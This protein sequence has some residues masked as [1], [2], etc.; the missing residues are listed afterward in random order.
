MLIEV[1]ERSLTRGAGVY[2]GLP[3]GSGGRSGD[4]SGVR[5]GVLSWRPERKAPVSTISLVLFGD[6]LRVWSRVDPW[7]LLWGVSKSEDGDVKR[8]DADEEEEEVDDVLVECP[9]LASRSAR[10]RAALFHSC[11]WGLSAA[12]PWRLAGEVELVHGAE[13]L[14]WSECLSSVPILALMAWDVRESLD[15]RLIG[16]CSGSL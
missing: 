11:I 8:E 14:W 2:G 13:G 10:L 3:G 6:V 16:P 7:V 1:R 12:V 9:S 4:P 15:S 5:G